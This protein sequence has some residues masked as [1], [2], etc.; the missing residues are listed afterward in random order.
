MIQGKVRKAG[1]LERADRGEQVPLLP[2]IWGE[3]G[4]NCALFELQ[5]ESFSDFDMIQWRSKTLYK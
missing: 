4:S 5:Q 3:Q 1:M 2:F